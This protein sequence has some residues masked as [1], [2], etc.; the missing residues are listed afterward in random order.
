MTVSRSEHLLA[1]IRPVPVIPVIVIDDLEQAIPLAKALVEGGLIVLEI[2]LRTSVALQAVRLIRDAVPEAVVGVGSVLDSFQFQQAR[3]AG[4]AFAVSPGTTEELIAA[5]IDQELPWLPAAQ[6]VSEM[7]RLRQAGY[8]FLKFFPA[9]S[10]GGVPFLR[11]VAGP[12]SD[13]R[14]CPTGGID[15]GK[16]E[17]Y[18]KLPNVACVGG[19]WMCSPESIRS[20]NWH[21]ISAQARAALHLRI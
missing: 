18:L 2:T 3:Q 4:A 10:S 13:M 5:A 21:S 15:A 20:A 6:T 8:R 11:S 9:E 16:A 1:L 19:S 7:M 14:F 12:V 17:T